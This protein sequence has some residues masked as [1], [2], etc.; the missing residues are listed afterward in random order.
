MSH[1]LP[2]GP[3]SGTSTVSSLGL[4]FV[5]RGDDTQGYEQNA[6]SKTPAA[7]RAKSVKPTV[8]TLASLGAERLAELLMAAAKADPSLMRS[9]ALEVAG[10]GGDIALEID[11]Q[12]ARLRRGTALL[13]AKKSAGL[14]RELQTLAEVIVAKLGPV[15]PV[16]GVERLLGLL[17]LAPELLERRTECGDALAEVF[18]GLNVRIGALLASAPEGPANRA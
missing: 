16:G 1:G 17:D 14:A 5:T 15:E 8:A 11:R 18:R 10:E 6:M 3:W 7:R 13:N 2:C 4:A 12:I 9:L